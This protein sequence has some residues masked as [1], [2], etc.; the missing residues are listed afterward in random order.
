MAKK[1]AILYADGFEDV[2]A[3]ATRDVLLRGGVEVADLRI[4]NNLNPHVVQAS[5]GLLLAGFDF[6][7]N[8]NP[9]E[10]DA[11]ILP[12]GGL[13]TQNLLKSKEVE[14]Y[15]KYMNE[16]NKLMCAICAAPMVLGKYGLL[17]NKKFTCF[18]GC[19][20]G[21]DGNFT[22]KEVEIDGNI[23]TG[24]SMLYSVPFGLAILEYLLG[25]DAKE[26]VYKQIEGLN[27][28]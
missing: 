1:V 15:L 21:L 23:I 14:R 26:R 20:E 8:H 19:N 25:K 5:H 12:G 16:N 3:L 7:N 9:N 28:K 18:A 6:A 22:A 24:R 4:E 11:V 27:R 17:H 2:E 10:F 13:G